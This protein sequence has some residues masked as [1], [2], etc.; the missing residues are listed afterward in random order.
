MIQF[1][2]PWRIKIFPYADYVLTRF[3]ETGNK[4]FVIS[5]IFMISLFVNYLFCLR[6]TLQMFVPIEK[7]HQ[8]SSSQTVSPFQLFKQQLK[9]QYPLL[10]IKEPFTS[11]TSVT[12]LRRK[13]LTVAQLLPKR[14]LKCTRTEH[15]REKLNLNR[16]CHIPRLEHSMPVVL[17]W[18]EL[19]RRPKKLYVCVKLKMLINPL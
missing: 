19:G 5:T 15:K 8:H 7:P 10:A 6:K 18:K 9:P 1:F 12:H 14:F 13:P 2:K 3:T 4:S 11:C 17:Q 16:V